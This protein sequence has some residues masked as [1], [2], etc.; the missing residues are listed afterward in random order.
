MNAF[1]LLDIWDE[2][3]NKCMIQI[4]EDQIDILPKQKFIDRIKEIL[5]AEIK[6]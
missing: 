5:S 6:K 2:F 3:M 4:E 1:T